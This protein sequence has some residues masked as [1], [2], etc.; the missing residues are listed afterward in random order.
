MNNILQ[1]Y[2][3]P[4][5]EN[6]APDSAYKP[7]GSCWTKYALLI[8]TISGLD[9]IE[10]GYGKAQRD[11]VMDSCAQ[12]ISH[13]IGKEG[14]VGRATVRQL[15]VVFHYERRSE[16]DEMIIRVG[17]C[18]ESIR[19][20]NRIRCRLKADVR[21][22][23]SDRL[24]DVDMDI[25]NFINI[26]GTP[27][28]Q[29]SSAM[30]ETALPSSGG[31]LSGSL[32]KR[33]RGLYKEKL[34]GEPSGI[35]SP[36]NK[37]L[38]AAALSIRSDLSS[39]NAVRKQLGVDAWM[40]KV[41][42]F[43]MSLPVGAYLIRRDRSIALWNPEAE[44][45]TGFP[46][47]EVLNFRGEHPSIHHYSLDGKLLCTSGCPVSSVFDTCEPVAAAIQVTCK[48]GGLRPVNV[49]MVPLLDED[50]HPALVMQ[51]FT[52]AEED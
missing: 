20:V 8:C 35:L 25:L 44:R 31:L 27:G 33:M 30:P 24:S 34:H 42:G 21:E 36:E 48:N 10:T 51:L 6:M 4:E 1:F 28:K 22:F 50:N 5:T 46:A 43:L 39:M 15:A 17:V 18:V 23:F 37:L 7:A 32:E 49:L 2:Q 14:F 9:P 52:A 41:S 26:P 38:Q 29:L 19:E 13:V 40:A 3:E 11:A 16:A 45:I 12:R 47:E